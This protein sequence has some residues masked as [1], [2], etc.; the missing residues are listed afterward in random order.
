MTEAKPR[1]PLLR[2]LYEERM[3]AQNTLLKTPVGS[4][5]TM[6]KLGAKFVYYRAQYDMLV[7]LETD[8]KELIN[9]GDTIDE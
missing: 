4:S 3:N 9:N 7:N 5:D 2:R 8:I 1:N 6:E